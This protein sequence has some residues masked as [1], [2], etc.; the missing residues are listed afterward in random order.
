MFFSAQWSC[1]SNLRSDVI[2]RCKEAGV[3]IVA[4]GPLFTSEPE[5][6]PDVDHL[7]LNEG[8][9]TLPLFLADLERGQPQRVYT[10][11][12][13]P[14]I[15]Q[16]PAPM[17]ELLDMRPYATISIQFSRGCP[18]DCEF[19]NITSLFGH[20]PRTKTAHAADR[21]VGQALRHWAGAGLSFLSTT[22]LS[23]TRNSSSKRSCP[24]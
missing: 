12:E 10:S 22:T 1:K 3:P 8:E 17:W 19:C 24:P 23:A 11:D 6:F 13:Y 7:V 18:Y 14:D 20:R 21:R 9:I 15:T 4:G 2:A 5:E 16:T